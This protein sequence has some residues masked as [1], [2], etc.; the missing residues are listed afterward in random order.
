MSNTQIPGPATSQAPKE[1]KQDSNKI[2]ALQEQINF[3]TE[4]LAEFEKARNAQ[5]TSEAKESDKRSVQFA[6]LH[7]A[8]FYPGLGQLPESMDCAAGSQQPKLRGLKMFA[9]DYG[10]EVDLRGRTGFIPWGNVAHCAFKLLDKEAAKIADQG[11]GHNTV[12]GYTGPSKLGT[13]TVTAK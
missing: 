10:L 11:V 7:K 2:K 5:F 9:T 13:A 6:Q 12:P 8:I 4:R 1:P 3:L